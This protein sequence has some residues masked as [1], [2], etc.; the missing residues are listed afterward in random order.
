MPEA[1]TDTLTLAAAGYLLIVA[2]AA[3]LGVH[4]RL[5]AYPGRALYA[6]VRVIVTALTFGR[7]RIAPLARGAKRRNARRLRDLR[8]ETRE[9]LDRARGRERRGGGWSTGDDA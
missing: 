3:A 1:V 7:V 9:R 5:L 4:Q 8:W 6:T 2:A